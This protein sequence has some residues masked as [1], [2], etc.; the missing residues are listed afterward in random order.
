VREVAAALRPLETDDETRG[1]LASLWEYLGRWAGRP[2]DPVVEP[3]RA[4]GAGPAPD[5][6][7]L[8]FPSRR[9][10]ASHLGI[11]RERLPELFEILARLVMEYEAA[12]RRRSRRR[13]QGR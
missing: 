13:C 2:A 12:E 6:D 7:E 4:G 3:R 1:Q 5:P 8:D 11:P 10:I 9:K